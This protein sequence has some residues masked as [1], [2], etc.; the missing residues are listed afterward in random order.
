MDIRTRDILQETVRD[1]DRGERVVACRFLQLVADDQT[2]LELGQSLLADDAAETDEEIA[3]YLA[4]VGDAAAYNKCSAAVAWVEPY[5]QS[6]NTNIRSAAVMALR[7]IPG[8]RAE[9]L[10]LAIANDQDDPLSSVAAQFLL[11]RER[12]LEFAEEHV[13][14]GWVRRS[15]DEREGVGKMGH[16]CAGESR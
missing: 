2:S 9:G 10:L 1:G 16:P 3:T 6:A 5:L 7:G 13:A 15:G 14:P 11:T 8:G 12:T 4:L